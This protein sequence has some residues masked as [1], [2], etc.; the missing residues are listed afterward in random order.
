MKP[1]IFWLRIIAVIAMAIVIWGIACPF[2]VSASS[3]IL[4]VLGFLL[5]VGILFPMYWVL[6]PCYYVLKELFNR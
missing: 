2:L 5:T 3:T 1:E 4:V 6:K